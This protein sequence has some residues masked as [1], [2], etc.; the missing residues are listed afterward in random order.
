MKKVNS[1]ILSIITRLRQ[2]CCH[3]SLF[4]SDYDGE[5]AKLKQCIELIEGA[6]LAGHKNITFL[7]IYINV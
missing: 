5:S 4:V 2:I 6:I 7:W 3:P 1:K